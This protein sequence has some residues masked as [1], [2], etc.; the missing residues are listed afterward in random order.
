MPIWKDII[1][2]LERYYKCTLA[3]TPGIASS[4][5]QILKNII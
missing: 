1:K 5:Y 4:F 3:T 2:K